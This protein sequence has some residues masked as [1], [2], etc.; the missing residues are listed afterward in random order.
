MFAV[1]VYAAAYAIMFRRGFSNFFFFW[2]FVGLS[3]IAFTILYR[4][5]KKYVIAREK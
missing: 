5:T 3:Y 2:A 4:V 1:G